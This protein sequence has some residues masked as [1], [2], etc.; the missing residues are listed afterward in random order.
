MKARR[1]LCWLCFVARV[2][3]RLDAESMC[4]VHGLV[5][6]RVLGFVQVDE[7]ILRLASPPQEPEQ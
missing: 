7:R 3:S 6:D 1:P 4:V 5:K 2:E